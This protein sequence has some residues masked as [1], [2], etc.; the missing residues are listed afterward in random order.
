MDRPIQEAT[1]RRAA[2]AG[3]ALILIACGAKRGGDSGLEKQEDKLSYAIGV[4]MAQDIK[5]ER[6]EV[7]PDLVMRGLRDGLAGKKLILGETEL[8]DTVAAFNNSRKEAA[9]SAAEENRKRGEA[10]LSDNGKRPGVTTLPSGLQYQVLATGNLGRPPTDDDVA[11]CHYRGTLI[12]GTEFDSSAGRPVPFTFRVGTVIPGW[13]EALH[14]MPVGSK[15]RI[16]VPPQLGYG[17]QGIKTKSGRSVPPN[18]TLVFDLELLG[19]RQPSA[20]GEDVGSGVLR[21]GADG[22]EH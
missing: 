22:R 20:R 11:V 13:R 5:R 21:A 3:I 14:L 7:D 12:D 19:V 4:E 17:E 8:R 1:M 2:A 15:W 6:I 18:A 9:R 16:V 10:F